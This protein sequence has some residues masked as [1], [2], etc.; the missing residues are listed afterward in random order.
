MTLKKNVLVIVKKVLKEAVRL[1]LFLLIL[2]RHAAHVIIIR[3]PDA[4]NPVVIV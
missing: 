4:P 1:N 3:F 2:K